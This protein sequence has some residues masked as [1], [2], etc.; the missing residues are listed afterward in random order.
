MFILTLITTI[1]L[2]LVCYWGYFAYRVYSSK[3]KH[4]VSSATIYLT[5]ETTDFFLKYL[6]VTSSKI[7]AFDNPVPIC[8]LIDLIPQ[9]QVIK[10]VL[11][12][13]GGELMDCFKIL[14][15][16]KAHHAGYIAYIRREC[17]SSGTI[18]ALGAK[19]IVMTT[20]DS[21]LGKIDPQV[22]NST[23]GE[24]YSVTIYHNLEDKFMT[25][26][27]FERYK[28]SQ[29]LLNYCREVFDQF[30]CLD[31]SVY[32]DILYGQ[33]PHYK[34][35]DYQYCQRLGLRTRSPTPGEEHFFT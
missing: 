25:D 15:K 24:N 2:G 22:Y 31:P 12:T 35:Y 27:I 4:D 8:L 10:V 26:R 17:M 13:D 5:D 18:I 9:D 11:E 14:R 7:G 19:E 6:G 30:L 20:R 32:Q 1:G 29:H 28:K 33:T 3:T 34:T 16:L 23:T 21:Y